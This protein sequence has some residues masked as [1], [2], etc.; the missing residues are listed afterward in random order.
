MTRIHQ[1]IFDDE[2]TLALEQNEDHHAEM[3]REFPVDSPLDRL[4][5]AANQLQ[6]K[7]EAYSGR[8]MYG[9]ECPSIRGPD[10]IIIIEE[11]ATRDLRGARTESLGLG[12]V[13]YWPALEWDSA[14][15]TPDPEQENTE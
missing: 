8:S 12:S 11:A 14:Y 4:Y 2:Q 6:L 5:H 7:L 10:T 3:A 9:K 13:V 15:T 1:D